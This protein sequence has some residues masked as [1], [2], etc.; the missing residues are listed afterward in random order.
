MRLHRRIGLLREQEYWLG[1]WQREVQHTL[2]EL[3]AEC[4]GLGHSWVRERDDDCH[5]LGWFE[6]CSICGR[7]QRA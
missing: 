6:V 2:T 3:S 4:D 5:S 1:V 7:V